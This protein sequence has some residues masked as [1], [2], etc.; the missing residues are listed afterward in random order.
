[1]DKKEIIAHFNTLTLNQQAELI[2]ELRD[3]RH[4][5]FHKTYRIVDIY[6]FRANISDVIR[7][8]TGFS[9]NHEPGSYSG[10]CGTN[11]VYIPH[12]LYSEELKKA[13]EH[14]FGDYSKGQTA[15]EWHDVLEKDV[16]NA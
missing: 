8:C 1:M 4:D 5:L 12:E 6:N 13:L 16:I 9:C 11:R 14:Y 2:N 10:T 7:K 15:A 3:I